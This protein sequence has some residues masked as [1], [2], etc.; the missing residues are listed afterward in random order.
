[1]LFVSGRFQVVGE[2]G[3]FWPSLYQGQHKA[4]PV[5]LALR[6]PSQPMATALFRASVFVSIRSPRNKAK[7]EGFVLSL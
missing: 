1:M 3:L 2:S 6:C 5:T 7:E 4:T